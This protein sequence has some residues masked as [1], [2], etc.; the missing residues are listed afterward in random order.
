MS[1]GARPGPACP[2]FGLRPSSSAARAHGRT[3]GTSGDLAPT[4][5]VD[6]ESRQWRYA[7]VGFDVALLGALAAT[8]W[9]GF[10]RRQLVVFC[11]LVSAVPL[12]CDAWFD[13]ML[14]WGT[15]DLWSSLASALLVELPLAAYLLVRAVRM[16]RITL[17]VSWNRAGA[18]GE[19]PPLRRAVLFADPGHGHP[20]AG[21]R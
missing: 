12:T 21:R 16:V 4:L 3:P 7:W 18:P 10:R 17:R 2:R 9:F 8:A 19:P 5:P 13:V 6:Y 1:V 14:P 20:S 11:C 15:S